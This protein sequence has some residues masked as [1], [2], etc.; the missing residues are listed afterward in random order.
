MSDKTPSQILYA[1]LDALKQSD[2]PEAQAAHRLP[3]YVWDAVIGPRVPPAHDPRPWKDAYDHMQSLRDDSWST[4]ITFE[5]VEQWPPPGSLMQSE[6]VG[7]LLLADM[8]SLWA[9]GGY[10]CLR[11][12][13]ND[14]FYPAAD[15]ELILLDP[16]TDFLH[17]DH[18]L[19]TYYAAVV[20]YKQGDQHAINKW[21]CRQ[22]NMRPWSRWVQRLKEN[23]QW[24]ADF[25]ALPERTDEV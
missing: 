7:L 4:T 11:V 12:N 17:P 1:L 23:G 5:G 22:R 13:A 16:C 9:Q 25:E 8:G 24:D 18:P 14:W 2:L 15:A 10:P 19:V 3:D 21:L 20:A 6:V